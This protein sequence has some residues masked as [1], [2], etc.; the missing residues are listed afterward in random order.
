MMEK[1]VT[2]KGKYFVVMPLNKAEVLFLENTGCC[3]LS[4]FIYTI[5]FFTVS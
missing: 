4:S 3:H 2:E 1:R 5:I